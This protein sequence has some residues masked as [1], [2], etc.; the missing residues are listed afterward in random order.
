[1]RHGSAPRPLIARV[2]PGDES[3]LDALDD[4]ARACFGEGGFSVREELGRA[5]TR[6][7]AARPAEGAPPASF[8]V[9]WHVAD[10]LHV[11]NIATTPELRRAGLARALMDE[12]LAYAA[13]ERVRILLLEVRR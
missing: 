1:M 3:E 6:A 2:L 9:A 7:W 10:E 5:W 8:L 11:L 4:I 12:A 13:S